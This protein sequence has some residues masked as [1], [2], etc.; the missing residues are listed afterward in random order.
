MVLEL[1]RGA[2]ARAVPLCMAPAG[3]RPAPAS[4]S[5]RPAAPRSRAPRLIGEGIGAESCGRLPSCVLA[6]MVLVSFES[7]A[8]TRAS[9]WSRGWVRY[10]GLVLLSLSGWQLHTSPL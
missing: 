4:R 8:E 7:R 9:W 5:P 2:A 1:A 10:M 3:I 6:D